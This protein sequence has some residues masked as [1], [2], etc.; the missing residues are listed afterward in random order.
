VL[1]RTAE[2]LARGLN[3][4][5]AAAMLSETAGLMTASVVG[6]KAVDVPRALARNALDLKEI[7]HSQT[8]LCAPLVPAGGAPL[9]LLYVERPEPFTAQD[10]ALA[11][12]LG[13]IAGEG[14]AAVRLRV[15][16]GV[17]DGALVGASKPFRRA[18]E[19]VRRAAV[20]D[21]PV[22]I[23]GEAGTGRTALAT[24]IHALSPRS[25]GPFVTVECRQDAQ[26][27][28]RELFGQTGTPGAPPRSAAL[29]RADGG[30]LMLRHINA[31][32]KALAER[33]AHAIA[34]KMATAPQG[35]EEP[36]DVR[37]IAS[38][39]Q[40]LETLTSKEGFDEGLARALAGVEIELSP[41]RS[42]QADVP[43]LVEHFAAKTAKALET[44]PFTL[45]PDA[46][47]LLGDYV[48]PGN[49]MELKLM[50]ERLALLYP[51]QEVPALKL[52]PEVQLLGSGGKPNSL[53]ALISNLE[54]QAIS[55]A[56]REARGKKIKAAALLGI[57]RPTL[58]KKIEDYGLVVEKIRGRR[59]VPEA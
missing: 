5:K 2:E 52:P 10:R 31:L 8:E 7:S 36:V 42:R 6:A 34:R 55:E 46:R 14:L 28:E 44:V 49:V 16:R 51:G 48:W 20:T 30:T 3:A 15:G 23:V 29:L 33:L 17:T 24:L 32:P 13:R 58:D 38:A 1:R 39:G 12:A 9:G 45:T 25:L 53:D 43:L 11:S 40:P 54:R 47:R 4:D 19:D 18:L 35:G 41:L 59:R 50:S 37:I 56:L 26:E 22:L 57:S 21:D 27:V